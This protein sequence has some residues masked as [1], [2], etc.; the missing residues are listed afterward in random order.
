MRLLHLVMNLLVHL[1][2]DMTLVLNDRVP[3]FEFKGELTLKNPEF[4]LLIEIYFQ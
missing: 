1:K 4:L 2:P 3:L